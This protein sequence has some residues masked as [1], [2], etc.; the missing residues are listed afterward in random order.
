VQQHQQEPLRLQQLQALRTKDIVTC[1]L[2]CSVR[3]A[4]RPL[5][6]A[7]ERV[8]TPLG[9]KCFTVGRNVALPAAPDD[10]VRQL[11]QSCDCLVGVATER[12]EAK[13]RDAPD[14]SLSLATPYLLQE[15]SMAFQ[16]DMPF[17]ILRADGVSLQG[18]TAKNLYITI[19]P[20]LAASG[21]VKFKAREAALVA[22]LVELKRLA[23]QRRSKRSASQVKV[24]IGWL[25][26]IVVTGG[27]LLK[28]GD[29]LMRPP[30]FG[31]FYY[32]DPECKDCSYKTRC[33]AEKQ[34]RPRRAVV[35]IL[36]HPLRRGQARRGQ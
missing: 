31:T 23:L 32:Q 2:S 33:K 34:L 26:S 16:A 3:P 17:L 10:A 11:M 14:R 8:L 1:F 18:V 21:R 25:S 27:L 36:M 7:V 28:G 9:F 15:T 4:A 19:D 5:V 20:R 30:C 6:D 22:T 29:S 13:E 24:A 12:L 35:S